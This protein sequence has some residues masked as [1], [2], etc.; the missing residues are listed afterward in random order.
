MNTAL[1]VIDIQNLLVD[2][3]PYAIEERLALWQETIAA[4]RQNQIE[5]IYIRHNDEEFIPQTYN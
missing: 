1:L 3:N 5:V 4:A 2:S